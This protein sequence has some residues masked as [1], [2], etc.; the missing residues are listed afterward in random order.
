MCGIVGI[1]SIN[2]DVAKRIEECKKMSHEMIHRGP[3]DE[4]FFSDDFCTLA[5]R[6]L[7]IID[8]KSGKQPLYSVDKRYL[9]FFNGEIYNYKILRQQLS[10]IGVVLTSNSDTEVVVNLF[11][12]YGKEMHKSSSIQLSL[13]SLH[14][15]GA[16]PKVKNHLYCL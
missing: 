10:Q 9:I 1:I 14:E 5:M 7:A 4:G 15:E 16:F 3:D 8:L 13:N 2:D 11:A 12:I 6:R